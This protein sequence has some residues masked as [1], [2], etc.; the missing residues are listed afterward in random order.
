MSLNRAN[1]VARG[2]IQAIPPGHQVAALV[3]PAK[4]SVSFFRDLSQG[5]SLQIDS[6]DETEGAICLFYQASHTFRVAS[7]REGHS[8][9]MSKKKLHC[10]TFLSSLCEFYHILDASMSA[11][12]V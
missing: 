8:P 12:Q 9:H 10:D 4:A 7:S 3:S 5:R 6:L 11:A 2:T 1:I